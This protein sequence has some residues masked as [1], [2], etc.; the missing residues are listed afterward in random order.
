MLTRIP[1]IVADVHLVNIVCM[2]PIC[3]WSVTALKPLGKILIGPFPSQVTLVMAFCLAAIA[4]QAT[5][6]LGVA[7]A[8]LDVPIPITVTFVRSLA[9]PVMLFWPTLAPL[10]LSHAPIEIFPLWVLFGRGFRKS[11]R[12]VL[13]RK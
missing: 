10:V 5:H 12:G 7:V 1:Y 13:E 8:L 6:T 11:G 2:Y 4:V 3:N 9:R